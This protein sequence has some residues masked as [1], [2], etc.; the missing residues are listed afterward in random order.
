MPGK[1]E[2]LKDREIQK[3]I[4]DT[5]NTYNPD[6][7]VD[8]DELPNKSPQTTA[9]G[10]RLNVSNPTVIAVIEALKELGTASMSDIEPLVD[11]SKHQVQRAIE[12]LRNHESVEWD[13]DGRTTV[14]SLIE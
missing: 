4:E 10:G 6:Y 12:H 7:H 2:R 3:A 8:N 14:Y 11:C 9:D 1:C 5:T 13:R